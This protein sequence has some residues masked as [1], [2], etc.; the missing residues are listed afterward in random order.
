MQSKTLL[1]SNAS[2]A[3]HSSGKSKAESSTEK[4]EF[5][6][7]VAGFEPRYIMYKMPN[8]V[9]IVKDLKGTTHGG[10]PK[11]TTIYEKPADQTLYRQLRNEGRTA[12]EARDTLRLLGVEPQP[13]SK[14]PD[15]YWNGY[16]KENKAQLPYYFRK[17]RF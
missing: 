5:K 8:G 6:Y 4:I 7:Q 16:V 14:V 2:G 12:S 1:Q 17:R 15:S 11:V 10:I 9:M 3:S 13:K